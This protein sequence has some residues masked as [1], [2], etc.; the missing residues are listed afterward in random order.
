MESY[1]SSYTLK[2]TSQE[3]L[4]RICKVMH[5][6]MTE[7]QI[8]E[9]LTNGEGIEIRPEYLVKKLREIIQKD[10]SRN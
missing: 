5:L 10:I 9:K 2:N 6:D 1:E 3:D 8:M 4:V 7:E